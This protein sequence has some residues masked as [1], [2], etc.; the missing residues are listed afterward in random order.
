[1]EHGTATEGMECACCYDDIDGGAGGNYVEYRTGEGAL[2]ARSNKC[3]HP[4]IHFMFQHPGRVLRGR[5]CFSTIHSTMLPDF[6]KPLFRD[7]ADSIQCR[8][9]EILP[10]VLTAGS[11]FHP[12]KSR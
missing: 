9:S 7:K 2:S 11:Y 1:M 4:L 5:A 3:N 8:G 12:V 6:V 10:L